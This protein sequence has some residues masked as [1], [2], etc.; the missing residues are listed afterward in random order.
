MCLSEW[1]N[2]WMYLMENPWDNGH[3]RPLALALGWAK[4]RGHRLMAIILSNAKRHKIF[5]VKVSVN[6][7]IIFSSCSSSSYFL[8][9]IEIPTKKG[10][11]IVA[12]DTETSLHPMYRYG[13][14]TVT[15][16]ICARTLWTHSNQ[17]TNCLWRIPLP[18]CCSRNLSLLIHPPGAL[19]FASHRQ[20]GRSTVHKCHILLIF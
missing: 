7:S 8:I 3:I 19:Q 11:R 5:Y 20:L 15:A 10:D 6:A 17:H 1:M 14:H 4:K 9:F 13:M 18:G 16:K 2:E 12:I